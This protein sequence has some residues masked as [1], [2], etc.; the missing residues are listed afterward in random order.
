MVDIQRGACYVLFSITSGMV[1]TISNV[2]VFLK[3]VKFYQHFTDT[4]FNIPNTKSQGN[5]QTFPNKA[6]VQAVSFSNFQNTLI[7][8]RCRFFTEL[9]K[10]AKSFYYSFCVYSQIVFKLNIGRWTKRV[11]L[12]QTCLI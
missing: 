10:F 6:R 8:V 2:D 1:I 3:N 4:F 7:Q 11:I 9:F 12:D 5:L